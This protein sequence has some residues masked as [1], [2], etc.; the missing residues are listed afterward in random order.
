MPNFSKKS[1]NNLSQAKP[2]LQKLFNEVI[3]E[4]DC[5]IVCGTRGKEEQEAAFNAGY[6]HA[7][8]GQS[9]HNFSPSWAVD[10]VPYPDQYDEKKLVDLSAIVKIKAI[11]M[12]IEITWGGDFKGNYGFKRDGD[13]PHYQIKDWYKKI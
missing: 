5:S 6:S 1:L 3:K 7:H 11:D 10:A 12:G 9:P 2:D 4:Y 13:L 8:Y